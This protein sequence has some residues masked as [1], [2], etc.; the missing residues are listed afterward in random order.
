MTIITCCNK[1]FTI[2][3]NGKETVTSS[4][5]IQDVINL[6]N[7]G[8][9]I[10]PILDKYCTVVDNYVQFAQG[11]QVPITSRE[12][13]FL[14]FQLETLLADD[15]YHI[16]CVQ[17]VFNNWSYMRNIVYNEFNDDIQ[18]SFLVLAPYDFIPK[19]LLDSSTFMTQ[20]N[21]NNIN[22]TISVNNGNEVYYN[23]IET[24]NKDNQKVIKTYHTINGNEFG[25]KKEIKYYKNSNNVE[26]EK[27]W[28][29]GKYDG[30]WRSWYDNDQHTLE[31]ED[32]YVDGKPDGVQRSWYNNIQHTLKFEQHYVDGKQNGV[33]RTWYDD[34]QHTL[35]FEQHYVDGKMDGVQKCWYNNDQHTLKSEQHYVNGKRHGQWL[36]F[37]VN[38]NITSDITYDNGVKQS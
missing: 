2:P 10:I 36:T 6:S 17:Q 13:L 29:D 1:Q 3:H 33:W 8:D 35:W 7:G 25:Y 16:Y 18:W 15:E 12:Q 20:W 32:H 38:G 21:E 26:I 14:C 28:V 11:N 27:H 22:K 34:D 5:Y 23:N 37:D 9:V 19:H 30:I 31:A 4:Q 24:L